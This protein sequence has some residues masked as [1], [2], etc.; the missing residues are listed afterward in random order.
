MEGD[1][2]NPSGDQGNQNQ[3]QDQSQSLGW[4]SALPDEYKEH[5]FVKS[6]TKPGDFVKSA[7]EIKTEHDALKTKLDSA[8]FKPDDKATPEQRE[9]FYRSLGKPEKPTE[10]EFPKVEGAEHDPAMVEWAQK[11]FHAANLNKEQ[12]QAIATAWDGF[13]AGIVKAD[14]EAREKSKAEA[15]ATIKAELGAEYNAATELCTRLLTKEA[16]PE[17]LAHLKESGLGNDPIIIR[18]IY[19]LAKKTDEDVGIQGSGSKGEKPKAGFNYDKS[20]PPPP[21]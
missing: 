14:T 19:R 9:A 4:R 8:I 16:K 12:A 1:Q 11:T 2:V 5:E 13:L 10:Y 15:E 6:F 21:K 3:N 17:E 18:L 7:L 20:P